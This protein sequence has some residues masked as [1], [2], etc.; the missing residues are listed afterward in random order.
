M[1]EQVLPQ[2]RDNPLAGLLEDHRLEIGAHHRKDQDTRIGR[3]HPKEGVQGEIPH[4]H[5]LHGADNQ[6]RN[7]IVDN[8]K[9]HQQAG[10]G[11]TAQIGPGIMGQPADNL[12]IRDIPLKAH[13]G[14][15]IFDHG[16]SQNQEH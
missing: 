8:R 11:K 6:G 1:G 16:I 7:D 14:L 13:R 9:E 10:H 12:T 2:V 3:H 15:F 4:Q 5:L